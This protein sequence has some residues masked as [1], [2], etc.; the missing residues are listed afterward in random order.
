LHYPL[1]LEYPE[2]Q[3]SGCFPEKIRGYSTPELHVDV[4]YLL[5][6]KA[7]R[8]Q[9]TLNRHNISLRTL[10]KVV[11]L[12]NELRPLKG[13]DIDLFMAHFVTLLEE[14]MSDLSRGCFK[15]LA[16]TFEIEIGK[17]LAE[18]LE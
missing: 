2:N 14:K 4:H 13:Q 18:L 10:C 16:Q 17:E 8:H 6:L 1:F 5:L 15:Y 3:L 11:T 7:S 9:S 12:V